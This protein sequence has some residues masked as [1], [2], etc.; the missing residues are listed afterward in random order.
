MLLHYI[1]SGHSGAM[2]SAIFTIL[3][4]DNHDYDYVKSL[5][6]GVLEDIDDIESADI[7]FSLRR[8]ALLSKID[9]PQVVNY[10]LQSCLNIMRIVGHALRMPINTS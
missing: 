4:K 5:I 1:T 10:T 2:S 8:I 7:P 6:A 9:Q 3:K